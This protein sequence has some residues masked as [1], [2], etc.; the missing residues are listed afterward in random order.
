MKAFPGLPDGMAVHS[1][2]TLFCSGPGGIYVMTPEGKLIGRIVTGGRTSNCTFD[3]DESNLYITN[4]A[5]L[6]RVRMK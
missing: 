6:C 3:E 2:G 5:N 4:D 1:S